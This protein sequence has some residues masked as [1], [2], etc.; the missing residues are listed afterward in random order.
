MKNR[1]IWEVEE[2]SG[3]CPDILVDQPLLFRVLDDSQDRI[4]G[5]RLSDA[6]PYSS[7]GVR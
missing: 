5:K 3:E 2:H 4:K 7:L 6:H 1:H